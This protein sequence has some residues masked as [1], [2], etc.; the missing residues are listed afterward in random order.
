[1]DVPFTNGVRWVEAIGSRNS[2]EQCM[3][4]RNTFART[5]ILAGAFACS[6]LAFSSSYAAEPPAGLDRAFEVKDERPSGTRDLRPGPGTP[7]YRK[8][9][10]RVT[11]KPS[12]PVVRIGAP[13]S[14]ELGSDVDGYAHVY[15]VSASGRVQVW[16]EN[17]QI[18]A[19]RHKLFPARGQ[20]TASA[21]AGRDDIVLVVT[22][23]RIKGFLG[24]GPIRTPRD[25]DYD[26][27][28]FKQAV[29]ERFEDLPRRDWGYARTLVH[30]VSRTRPGSE[31]DWDSGEWQ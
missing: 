24:Y 15:V 14:F 9:R 19:G 16:M 25:L 7:D 27:A 13:V 23:E 2:Q 18:A 10:P 3:P 11:L 30:V 21:P 26:P 1:L 29:K 12:S 5:T 22:R 17:V 8:E 31:W 28:T 6:G 4:V 20:I